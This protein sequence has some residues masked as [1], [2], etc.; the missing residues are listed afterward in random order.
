MHF[1]A[2]Y[3]PLNKLDI[4]ADTAFKDCVP[5]KSRINAGL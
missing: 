2:E 5:E 1:S 4:D 3:S